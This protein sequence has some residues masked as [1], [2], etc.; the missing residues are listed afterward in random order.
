MLFVFLLSALVLTMTS[1]TSRRYGYPD[2]RDDRG[3]YRY[4]Q[5]RNLADDLEDAT[6]RVYDSA[7]DRSGRR[8]DSEEYALDRL[9]NLHEEAKDFRDEVDDRSRDPRELSS[10]YRELSDA[11]FRARDALRIFYGDRDVYYEFERVSR[12]MSDLERLHGHRNTSGYGYP[13]PR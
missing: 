1:C 6:E 10:D 4:D 7:E 11:Y 12:I 13:G 2:Y 5:L 8:S 9:E 3:S